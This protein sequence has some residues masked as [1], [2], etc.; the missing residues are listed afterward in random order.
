M[1]PLTAKQE[2]IL[3][4]TLILFGKNGYNET[5]IQDIAEEV[6]LKPA[7]LYNHI[8]AKKEILLWICQ[9]VTGRLRNQLIEL[10]SKKGDPFSRFEQFV[11]AHIHSIQEYSYEFRIFEKYKNRLDRIDRAQQ[12][13]IYNDYIEFLQALINEIV[14]PS[15]TPDY[16]PSNYFSTLLLTILEQMPNWITQTKKSYP[17]IAKEVAASFLFGFAT[18]KS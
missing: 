8:S 15:T 3:E 1:T 16:F 2:H 18:P 7:S 4:K 13:E 14:A 12:N 17:E 9:R 5:S 10:K 6:G 11:E